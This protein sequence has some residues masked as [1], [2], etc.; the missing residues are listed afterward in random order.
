[1]SQQVL[2]EKVQSII[3]QLRHDNE[4]YR[5]NFETVILN[6]KSFLILLD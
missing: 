4:L 5:Q 1:M 3:Q 2:D 6:I